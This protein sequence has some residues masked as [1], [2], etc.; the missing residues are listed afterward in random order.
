MKKIDCRGFCKSDVSDASG[1]DIP[2]AALAEIVGALKHGDVIVYPSDTIYCLGADIYDEQ[3]IKKVFMIKK[4]PFD[5]PISVC[6]QNAKAA[7]AVGFINKTARKLLDAFTPGP[8]IVLVDKREDVPDLL[9]AGSTT[10]GIR[11]PDFPLA[12][13]ILEEFGPITSAS[14]NIHSRKNAVTVNTCIK[15]FGDRVS[16]YLDSG[17]TRYGMQSTIVDATDD[18]IRVVREGP[19]ENRRIEDFLATV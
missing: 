1:C 15:D 6:V 17:K 7:S 18:D 4:R 14:A 19:I 8:L 3:A 9:T 13:K 16:L 10:V 12:L 2:Q 11:I 5:M